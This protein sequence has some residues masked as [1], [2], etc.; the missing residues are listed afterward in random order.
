MT[1]LQRPLIIALYTV[2]ALLCGFATYQLAYKAGLDRLA[3][4]GLVRI[5]QANDRLLGQL[6]KIKIIPVLLSE[7]PIII[8]AISKPQ[9]IN[10]FLLD[11]ALVSGVDR[12][13]VAHTNGN[14]LASSDV[15]T[16]ASHLGK[17]VSNHPD[18]IAAKNGRLGFSHHLNPDSNAREFHYTSGIFSDTGPTIGVV[19]VH[20]N[21]SEL[22]FEWAIDEVPIAYFDA[23]NTIFVSNRP[24]LALRS[25]HHGPNALIPQ[26][27]R[28]WGHQIV[29][30]KNNSTLADNN[31]ILSRFIPQLGMTAVAF[32]DTSAIKDTAQM[33]SMLA[34]TLLTAL[35]LGLTILA[36]RR[37]SLSDQLALEEEANSKLEARV[38]ARTKQLRSAQNQLVQAGKLSALGQMAAN[39]SHELNQPL[40]AM[41][42]F[43]ENGTK[44]LAK[45]RAGEAQVNFSMI[46]TQVDRMTRIIRNLRAFSRKE[47][48]EIETVNL[49]DVIKDALT[50]AETRLQR[51]ETVLIRHGNTEPLWV[52]G[53]QIRL[54]QV[55]I[56]LLNNAMDA[57][58]HQETR[59][60]TLFTECTAETASVRLRDTGTGLENPN[61]V[62]EPFYSTKDRGASKGLGLGLSISYGII[63]SFGGHL[64]CKNLPE[65][66]AEFQ[67]DL[68]RIDQRDRP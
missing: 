36:Q 12:I 66:G 19:G 34:I 22:E 39:L 55:L 63:G 18:F 4:T 41:Q 14:V 67:L 20:I 42:N 47:N 21:I 29:R 27:D 13:Y 61:R 35:G 24:Q 40:A 30:F 38:E 52:K 68:N 1:L 46:Q 17:N 23:T 56:N 48:E 45:G 7:S 6:S 10:A 3:K 15:N 62:F 31:L 9:E 53:G 16:P 51:E 65:G 33:Q 2:F 5:A 59:C 28:F 50:L 57:M 25:F 37:Q 8:E 64:T 11:K 60:I 32:L 44:L 43:S 26:S 54:Q 58:A 49:Q